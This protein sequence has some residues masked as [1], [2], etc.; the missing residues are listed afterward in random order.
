MTKNNAEILVIGDIMLDQYF[1]GDIKRISPEAPVP[2]VDLL[3]IENRLGGAGN[4]AINIKNTGSSICIYSY[5]GNDKYGQAIN[6]LLSTNK[7]F[8]EII[9]GDEVATRKIRVMSNTNQVLRIDHEEQCNSKNSNKLIANIKQKVDSAKVV[10]ISDYSKG[11]IRNLKPLINQALK[12]NIPV[13][14]DPKSI[15]ISLYKNAFLITPNLKE[16]QAFTSYKENKSLYENAKELAKANHINWIVITMG[17]DG[18]LC[19]NQSGL[20]YVLNS[21]CSEVVDVT[22]AG[23]IVISYIAFALLKNFSIEDA[24]IYA[25]RAAGTSVSMLG[26]T[27]MKPSNVKFSTINKIY[28]LKDTDN[29]LKKINKLKL[30]GKKIVM[31]NGHIEYLTKSRQ[32]GDIL[33]VAM[34]SDRS[35]STIKGNSR[36]INNFLFRSKVLNSHKCID[37]IVEFDDLDPSTLIQNVNPHILT[38][39]ADYNI[40]DIAGADFVKKNNGEIIL[41]NLLDG[42]ST[43]SLI[44][45]IGLS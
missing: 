13:T 25:N 19:V 29:F 11:V 5:V 12:K 34:N 38:K 2:I 4:V 36:P 9:T 1:W 23:D 24:F 8:S 44:E 31:T 43:T 17:P 45:K 33:I 15:D 20:M 42:Y 41:I 21:E 28:E 7:I 3:N 10:I 30:S 39:G 40:N 27:A 32:L 26:T 35:V 37:F 22:G 16:F 6:V 14:V 18:I